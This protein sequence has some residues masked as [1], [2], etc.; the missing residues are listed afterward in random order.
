VNEQHRSPTDLEE[1]PIYS[2]QETPAVSIHVTARFSMDVETISQIHGSA[3][4]QVLLSLVSALK[5]LRQDVWDKSLPIR[6]YGFYGDSFVYEFCDEYSFTFKIVTDRDEHKTPFHQ[7]Y[8]LKTL[9][10]RR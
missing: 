6:R 7:H 10:R 9:L 2:E 3:A 8:F 1:K 5:R 4:D